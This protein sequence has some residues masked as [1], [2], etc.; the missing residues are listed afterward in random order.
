MSSPLSIGYCWLLPRKWD[1]EWLLTLSTICLVVFLTLREKNE[2][3]LQT[4]EFIKT[5][6]PL[7]AGGFL[8]LRIRLPG[9]GLL[10]VHNVGG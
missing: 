4:T 9:V 10:T 5:G 6:S 1:L 7:Y 3:E 2:P 8:L